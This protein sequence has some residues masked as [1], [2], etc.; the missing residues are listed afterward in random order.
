ME[1]AV[2]HNRMA[3]TAKNELS[4][5]SL[6]LNKLSSTTSIYNAFLMVFDR[7]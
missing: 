2:L 7:L 4:I 5:N 1:R 3:M 6:C